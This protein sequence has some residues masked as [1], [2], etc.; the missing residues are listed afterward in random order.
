ML[1]MEQGT[2][3]KITRNQIILTEIPGTA[4]GPRAT[5]ATATGTVVL[6]VMVG[7]K[8]NSRNRKIRSMRLNAEASYLVLLKRCIL[9]FT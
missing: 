7:I 3:K 9:F 1:K 2:C 5:G 6:D 8:N 4:V